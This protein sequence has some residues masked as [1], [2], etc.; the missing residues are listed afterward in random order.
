MHAHHPRTAW[1]YYEALRSGLER[2][3]RRYFSA[4]RAWTLWSKAEREVGLEGVRW[5]R[6]PNAREV[7]AIV[8]RLYTSGRLRELEGVKGV[9]Y[10]VLPEEELREPSLSEVLA[11]LHPG[12]IRAYGTAA[13]DLGLSNRFSQVVHY[14]WSGKRAEGRPENGAS[15]PPEPR[16]RPRELLGSS[17]Q[18]HSEAAERSEWFALR[19]LPVGGPEVRVATRERCLVD[20]L[21]HP[22]RFGGWSVVADM[23]ADA[24]DYVSLDKLVAYTEVV[25]SA[26]LRQRVGYLAEALDLTHSSFDGWAASASAGGSAVLVAGHPWTGVRDERWKLGLNADLPWLG[27]RR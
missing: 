27:D 6:L 18:W 23:W 5:K 21:R 14:V 13:E 22:D 10:L 4:W 25:G 8:G 1:T 3:E 12:A 9:Y 2:E 7:S 24:P 16:I 17:I 15:G 20:A 11:E 19:R 26:V